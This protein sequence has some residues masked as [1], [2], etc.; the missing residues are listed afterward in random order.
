MISFS[1]EPNSTEEIQPLGKLEAPISA[2]EALELSALVNLYNLP[3][4]VPI[5]TV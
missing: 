5:N 1:E 4:A 2:I 3:A